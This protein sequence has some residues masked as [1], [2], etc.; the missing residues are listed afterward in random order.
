MKKI[1]FFLAFLFSYS[2]YSQL[3]EGFEGT[4]L[5]NTT[6]DQWDL[7]A[8]TGIWGVFDNGVGTGISWNVSTIVNSGT[9]A[10]FMN[11]EFVG[12]GNTSQDYLATPSVNITTNGELRFW[13]RTNIVGDQGTVFKIMVKPVSVSAQ[14]DPT[15][16]V[17]LQQFSESNLNTVFNEYQ[18]K[19]VDIS[20]YAGQD[21][22]VA[23]VMEFTQPGAGVGGD[24][25]LLDDVKIVEKCFP[26]TALSATPLS[27]SAILSWTGSAPTYL[28]EVMPVGSTAVPSAANAVT[29]TGNSI[30]VTATT[31]PVA[32]IVPLT[33][34]I[35]YVLAQCTNSPSTWTGPFTFTTS[36]APPVCGGN[37]VDSGGVSANY[38]NNEDIT[39]TI[40]P[41]TAGDQVTVTFTA[42]STEGN[43]DGLYVFDGNSITSPQLASANG[44]GN[45]PGGLAGSYWGNTIPGPFTSSSLD[46]C[47]T[48]RFRSDGSAAFSG[49]TANVTC[50]PAPTC[51]KPTALS[52]A[53]VTSTTATLS[54]TN[55]GPGT[56]WE[57]FVVPCSAPAPTAATVGTPATSPFVITGLTPATCYNY[58]VKAICSDTD[59]STWAGPITFTTQIAPPI[60]GGN[61]V[62]PGGISANYANNVDST[63][64]ICPVNAGDQV[65]VTFTSF[66][67]ENT[68]DGLYVF[69]GNSITAPQIA[70]ANGGGNVPGGLPGS[71]WGNVIPG[72]FTSSSLDGCLTFR[73]RSD[74]S[75]TNPGWVANITCAPAPTCPKPTALTATGVTANTANLAWTNIGPA[76]AWEVF[77][78]PCGSLAP[79]ASSVGIAATNPFTITG[80]L[81]ATCYDYYVRA[82]CSDTDSSTWAGPIVF[83]TLVSC[84]APTNITT[85]TVTASAVTV[86]WTNNGSA[87]SWSVVAVL[88]GS[89]A[90]TAATVGTVTSA[91]PLVL[92]GLS[93]ATCYDIY[94]R[95]LC[96]GNDV[97]TWSGPQAVT[98]QPTPPVCG[99]NFLDIG[100][101]G[102]YPNNADTTVTICPTNPGDIVTVTFTSFS[103]E[104][105]WDGLY[106]FDGNSI[107]A[108]QIASANPAGN[109]PGGL[110]GSFWGNVIP[111]PFTSSSADGCLTFRFRSDGSV[112]NPGWVANITC[113]PPPN[114]PKPNSISTVFVTQTSASI[115]WNQPA[116][117]SGFIATAWGYLYFHLARRFPSLPELQQVIHIW[118]RVLL[119]EHRTHSMSGQYVLRLRQV[120]GP[121]RLISRHHQS[122]TNVPMHFLHPSMRI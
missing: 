112:T 42:F 20:T 105:T 84:P 88:C 89:L 6:T 63:I 43:F 26:P 102:D 38:A 21:V 55:V 33:T 44:A 41:Q 87:T 74:G 95:A 37:Y 1:I 35:Y 29:A 57:V 50:A 4:T 99:G 48:F 104:A 45:V 30:T 118:L 28:V 12:Q 90:P 119:L 92:T 9:R 78:V 79:T 60:C 103:T 96:D 72:P 117:P 10:A 109:V 14:N 17:L 121:D 52:A 49:W 86:G 59:S 61:F 76:T 71:F 101:T 53:T 58:Y 94:V 77:V 23:F 91:N 110:P 3:L 64:T 8:S 7:S 82:I 62:D 113:L 69:D 11:R 2:G 108:P 100:G 70:S 111:G 107:A 24:R 51:P 19:V 31:T 54:W 65:T 85:T 120:R 16:Y 97:S 39:I 116:N 93:S 106:V 68:W 56:V 98:T 13:T 36:A 32:P 81:S 25:W 66:S 47:L 122:M 34:Y 22:Y 46:G 15:G 114:C 67:T 5:P 73:F 115:T 27:T 80:L 83:T 40:C 18:E 75:V